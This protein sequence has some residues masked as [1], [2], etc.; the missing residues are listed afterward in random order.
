MN[1]EA[2]LHRFAPLEEMIVSLGLVFAAAAV[3]W[4]IYL[5]AFKGLHRFAGRTDTALDNSLVRRW[6]GP[7]RVLVPLLL[8]ILVAPSLKFP[9]EVLGVLRNLISVAFIGGLA[10][11]LVNTTFAVRDLF[12]NRYDV[13]VRDNLKARVVHTQVNVLVKI[14]LV[15]IF[16]IA[17]ASMLMTFEKIRQVGVSLLASAGLVGIIAGFAAQRSLATLIAGIQIAITQPIRI[18][19]VVIVEGEWGRIEEITLTYV[20]VRIWDLRRLVVPI[21]WFL[22]KPFQNWTRISADILGTVFLYTDYTVPVEALRQELDRV[23]KGSQ[24]W[25]GKVSGLVVTNATERSMELRALMSA[26]DSGRAWDL[27]CEVREKLID[28]IRRNYPESLPR[29]RAELKSDV[30][31]E[32]GLLGADPT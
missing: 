15:V 5:A 11:L 10:W 25:D 17:L 31:L 19:D 14:L 21:T 32:R 16:V 8:I 20:V 4:L 28:F 3:G 23:L 13:S 18:D 9:P 6:R 27:R 7:G 1:L 12:L 24:N 29:V 30:P 2:V 22:E 26:A